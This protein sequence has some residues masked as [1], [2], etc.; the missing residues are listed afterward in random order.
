LSARSQIA[1]RF[2]GDPSN[3]LNLIGVT[4]TNGKTTCTY[5]LAEALNN[6]GVPCGIIGTLGYGLNKFWQEDTMTTPDA[7][8]LQ[9][10]LA[11]LKSLGAKTVVMEVSSHGLDQERVKGLN[12]ASALFTNLTQDHLD[13]HGS[14]EQYGRAK[15]KLFE[16]R[17]LKRV[18]I[19]ADD[20]FGMKIIKLLPDNIA[21][22]LYTTQ[23]KVSCSVPEPEKQRLTITSLSTKD[24]KATEQGLSADLKSSW[25][26]KKLTSRLMGDFNLSNLLCALSELCLQ[27]FSLSESVQA[28]SR[29]YGAPGRMQRFGGASM[30]L[31]IIDY[32]H[33]PDALE[34]ALNAAKQHCQRR[35]WCVFGCGG[36]RDTRKRP[37]MGKI[38][39]EIADRVVITN[40]NPRNEPPNDIIAD[41]LRGIDKSDSDKITIEEDRSAAIAY[42]FRNALAY[43]VILVAGKGHE[44]YQQV[45]TQKLP[46]SDV[47]C[48]QNLLGENSNAFRTTKTSHPC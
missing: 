46:F 42:A 44:A 14:M 48:V 43:D 5:L 41:I 28:L 26:S 8:T 4:G 18:V 3:D 24:C 40:D 7:I 34:N 27:G 25:G 21:V 37:K 11:K 19:N 35:L 6:L 38:V 16:C 30:P 12:F 36:D 15:Q 17:S 32:A 23:A 22:N 13:Y 31:I 47:E 9:Q 45:G 39:A 29:A 2:Y 20:P 1:G 33:T 10:R